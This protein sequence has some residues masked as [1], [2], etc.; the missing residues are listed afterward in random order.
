M[1]GCGNV[2]CLSRYRRASYLDG[3]QAGYAVY[4][5]QLE[6]DAME[7]SIEAKSGELEQVWSELDSVTNDL[8]QSDVDG[9][10]RTLWVEATQKLMAHQT[11]LSAEIDELESEVGARKTQLTQM[12]HAIAISY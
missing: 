1:S 12:R 5:T 6:V 3:Y 4:M 11:R 7:R 9:A 2:E 8:E 10:S